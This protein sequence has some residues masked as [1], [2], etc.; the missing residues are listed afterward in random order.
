[1]SARS[2]VFATNSIVLNITR[3]GNWSWLCRATAFAKNSSRLLTV[4]SMLSQRVLSMGFAYRRAVWYREF[5]AGH[6]YVTREGRAQDRSHGITEPESSHATGPW[7]R[8]RG[9]NWGNAQES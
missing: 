8:A 1:M 5:L 7:A 3:L 2:R 6:S 9:P 4:V